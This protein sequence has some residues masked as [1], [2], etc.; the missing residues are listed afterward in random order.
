MEL[1]VQLSRE[2]NALETWY[3]ATRIKQ[4]EVVWLQSEKGRS[5][6]GL[7]GS[8]LHLALSLTPCCTRS[9]RCR[10]G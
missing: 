8:S 9:T 6:D 2:T 4:K 5:L 3:V 10:F 7:D 1:Q